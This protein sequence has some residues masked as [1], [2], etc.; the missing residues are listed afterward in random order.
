MDQHEKPKPNAHK[1]QADDALSPEERSLL[2]TLLPSPDTREKALAALGDQ[3][4]PFNRLAREFNLRSTYSYVEDASLD[5]GTSYFK[6]D[7][8]T[9]KV[10]S[11]QEVSISLSRTPS[12][13][14][15][16]VAV[17]LMCLFRTETQPGDVEQMKNVMRGFDPEHSSSPPAV[18]I[19]FQSPRVDVVSRLE[20][21]AQT[22]RTAPEHAIPDSDK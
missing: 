2:S 9:L 12:S 19:S 11:V 3:D 10:P 4:R 16:E 20:S 6:V 5:A 1:G 17:S 15:E 22:V 14:P 7:P 21:V 18:S 8:T 13:G